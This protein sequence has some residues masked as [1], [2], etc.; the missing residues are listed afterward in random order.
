MVWGSPEA[1]K[2][3][4]LICLGILILIGLLTRKQE[5]FW[6]YCLCLTT[7]L[8]LT[9]LNLQFGGKSRLL[10]TAV[11][12]SLASWDFLV[13]QK[14]LKGDLSISEVN[15]LIN[16]HLRFLFFAV[17]LG[18][19]SI[20]IA[21]MIQVELSFPVLLILSILALAGFFQLLS[22]AWKKI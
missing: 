13:F 20:E 10:Y 7:V 1:L 14:S 9:I 22:I 11:V 6:I 3:A 5:T 15:L 8:I 18:L 4:N 2:T 19:L 16:S 12:F 17:M 21:M